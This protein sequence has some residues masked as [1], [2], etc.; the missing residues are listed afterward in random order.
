MYLLLQKDLYNFEQININKDKDEKHIKIGKCIP[1]TSHQL[2]ATYFWA[3]FPAAGWSWWAGHC[4]VAAGGGE[5]GQPAACCP[6]L[7]LLQTCH[8]PTGLPAYWSLLH[9]Q[10][11]VVKQSAGMLKVSVMTGTDYCK[12][13]WRFRGTAEDRGWLL[14]LTIGMVCVEGLEEDR[15][16]LGLTTGMAW[17]EG[18]EAKLDRGYDWNWL[19]EWYVVTVYR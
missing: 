16:W 18:L 9:D 2:P 5:T 14:E 12:G 19:M 1:S 15:L 8:P 10:Q 6:S 17:F 3:C 4:V 11:S 13:M 7:L